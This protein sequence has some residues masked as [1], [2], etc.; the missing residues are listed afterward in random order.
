MALNDELLR[1][2]EKVRY[3]SFET[4][5]NTPSEPGV[6]CWLYPLRLKG[7]DLKDFI[8]EI[9]II[10]NFNYDDSKKGEPNTKF[11]MGWRSYALSREYKKINSSAPFIKKWE[12]LYKNAALSGDAI[13]LDELKKIM[14]I[15]SVFMPPL[16]IGKASDLSIRCQQHIVGT[17]DDKNN[18]HNRFKNY[19]KIHN[20]S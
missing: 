1:L 2:H 8:D 4:F 14:F 6:Y 11:N 7:C 20:T 13:D 17:T 16:Y 3:Y 10:F 9:N 5:K 12:K 18:F 15:S 19:A